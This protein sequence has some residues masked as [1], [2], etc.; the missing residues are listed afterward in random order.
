[1]S[2]LYWLRAGLYDVLM[3]VHTGSTITL[4]SV[5]WAD[6]STVL[7]SRQNS[8][9][10]SLLIAGQLSL[11]H[12]A[13]GLAAEISDSLHQLHGSRSPS[14]NSARICWAPAQPLH[15]LPTVMTYIQT[16]DLAHLLS[17]LVSWSL[18]VDEPKSPADS[19]PLLATA[20][21]QVR[22]L[23]SP[24]VGEVCVTI[25]IRYSLCPEP[26]VLLQHGTTKLFQLLKLPTLLHQAVSECHHQHHTPPPGAHQT[27]P[28]PFLSNT[29]A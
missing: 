14:T 25:P 16:K 1:M 11:L 13:A 26:H 10:R 7:F 20:L 8:E 27:T 28:S 12:K 23:S 22:R 5:Q 17:R 3:L 24:G 15:S 4:L 29:D 19:S 9:S 21:H 18:Y 6:E 2:L